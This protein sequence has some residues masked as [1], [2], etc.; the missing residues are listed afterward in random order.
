M[1]LRF[2]CATLAAAWASA[3]GLSA[4][5]TSESLE[6]IPWT[7]S[8]VRGSPE[9]PPPY[10]AKVAFPKLKFTNPV[11]LEF[12]PELG[13]FFL[14][15]QGGKVFSFQKNT[16]TTQ[17]DVALDLTNAVP[18]MRNG[19][20]MA[21]HPGFAT[22]RFLYLCYTLAD[23][24]P[25][26]TRVSRFVVSKTDPPKVDPASESILLTWLSGGHN[27]GCLKFGPDGFLYISTGDGT[28]PS[29]PDV[30]NTGQDLSDLLSSIL[31]IDVDHAAT[32]RRYRVPPDN[33]FVKMAGARPEIWAY[34]LR[35]PWRMSFDRTQGDLWV[36]D[37]GWELWEMIYRVERGGNYGWSVAEGPQPVKPGD[38]RGPTPILPPVAAHSHAE[39]ASITGGFVYRGR[40]LADLYGAYIYGDWVTGKFWALRLDGPRA[41]QPQELASTT[42]KIVSFAEDERGELYLLN[43]DGTIHELARN[44]APATHLAFPRRLSETGLFASVPDGSPAPGVYPYSVNAG[45]WVDHASSE[46]FVALPGRSQIRPGKDKWDFPPD[47]VLARTLSMEMKRNEPASR[48]RLETQLLH[49]DGLNWQGYAYRWNKEQTDATLVEANGADVQIEVADPDAPAGKRQQ[50]WHFASRAECL[51][52]HNPWSGPPLGFNSLQLNRN[53][54]GA[55]GSAAN[56]L[57][58]ISRVSLPT[59][60]GNQLELLVRRGL[61]AGSSPGIPPRLTDPRDL[62]A[63][64]NE[65]ARSWLH[66]NCAH[67][68][69]M[70]AGGSV[71]ALMN[72]EL[73]LAKAQMLA[74][75]PL[76][77]TFGLPD[78]RIIAPGEPFRSVLYYRIATAGQ[79]HM[80]RIGSTLVDVAGANL[81]H[82]WIERMPRPPV[83]VAGASIESSP[84][85]CLQET[86]QKFRQTSNR[87]PDQLA[88]RAEALL[89]SPSGALALVHEIDVGTVSVEARD[90][91]ARQA[92]AAANPVIREL[93]GQFLPVEL[94]PVKLG[95]VIKPANVLSHS[96]SIS[97]GRNLFFQEGGAQC[98][99]CHRLQGQGRDFGPDLS[100][101]ASKYGRA[102]LLENILEPSKT[103]DPL[104]A[105]IIVETRTGDSYS[106]ILVSK[107][108]RE[109][110]LKDATG[111]E[112]RIPVAAIARQDAQRLSLMP[113]GLLA[114]LTAQDAADLL[115]FLGSL[116]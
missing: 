83:I 28:S 94:R 47:T 3:A 10:V 79:G 59:A 23:G 63:D 46:R 110:V 54:G 104:F 96:G 36:G 33:P 50:T 85:G 25:E 21:F 62:T 26:G 88:S 92:M 91:I 6:R 71:L 99:N 48:R 86:L 109:L 19:Y 89:A 16:A 75:P 39:A 101:I 31:R 45:Q 2:G 5:P 72:Y 11:D 17:L 61:L 18:A 29:P 69:R 116:K 41:G 95:A 40:Q 87:A 42:M 24:L 82:D 90:R 60:N 84:P 38:R 32:G 74:A 35:N 111:A 57:A 53:L 114:N 12:S 15:E 56:Q 76:Q 22:N 73:P 113:E 52:C 43:Y 108:D 58:S 67:C 103:I 7:T 77:G 106:G 100:H 20:G 9:A 30:L 107:N 115:E 102:Q 8:R 65:R 34:G 1:Y 55:Q 4:S 97:R 44:P 70:N 93:F 13:R 49:F 51:R 68:H 78:G 64:V 37:V 66:A 81:I 80:P 14:L 98:A 27:G 105:G 112:V